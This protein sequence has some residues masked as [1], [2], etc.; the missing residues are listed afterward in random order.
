MDK[1]GVGEP[2]LGMLNASP[3]KRSGAKGR[4]LEGARA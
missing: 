1:I 2:Q 3:E 4:T